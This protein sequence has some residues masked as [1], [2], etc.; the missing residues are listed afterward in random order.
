MEYVARYH[1]GEVYRLLVR[2]C[3]QIR[4]VL[5]GS[6]HGN[7]GSR[8]TYMGSAVWYMRDALLTWHALHRVTWHAPDPMRHADGEGGAAA[9]GGAGSLPADGDG[10]GWTPS[11]DQ[12]AARCGAAHAVVT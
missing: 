6:V 7:H 11:S 8:P 2:L 3:S 9:E 4:H 5:G 1:D 10:G 12:I